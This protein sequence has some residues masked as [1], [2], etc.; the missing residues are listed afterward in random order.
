MDHAIA[1]IVGVG[2]RIVLR[3]L[4]NGDEFAVT[5]HP[6][7]DPEDPDRVAPRSPIAQALLGARLDD[8]VSW[9]TPNGTARFHITAILPEGEP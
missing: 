9:P 2:S 3:D 1:P 7:A 8:V 4:R 6:T 5:I